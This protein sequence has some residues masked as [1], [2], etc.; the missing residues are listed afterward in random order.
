VLVEAESNK[1]GQRSI[2]PMLW[3]AMKTAKSI[4]IDV[5]LSERAK[6]LASEY[7]DLIASEGALRTAL[8]ELRRYRGH[9]TVDRWVALL[10][11]GA[12]VALAEA[13]MR[14]HYDPAY[15]KSRAAQDPDVLARFEVAG[16]AE[17][18]RD[19]LA[20]QIADRMRRFTEA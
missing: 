6:F 11:A 18:Q 14:D 13:L 15:A 8:D 2:P 16:L 9:E 17:P 5:G 20:D 19:A 3:A 10:D 7:S 1:I 12:H 4:K